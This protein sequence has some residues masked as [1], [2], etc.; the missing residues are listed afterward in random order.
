MSHQVGGSAS[1]GALGV[2]FG[3]TWLME[4]WAIQVV[5]VVSGGVVETSWSEAVGSCKLG[6]CG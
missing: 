1:V 3:E 5:V 4:S 6:S 2:G